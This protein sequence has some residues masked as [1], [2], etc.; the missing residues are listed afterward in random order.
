MVAA[1]RVGIGLDSQH[2]RPH[3]TGAGHFQH[4]M[5]EAGFNF[6]Q[7]AFKSWLRTH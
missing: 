6:L 1:L 5:G 4:I 7:L 2:L 3:G